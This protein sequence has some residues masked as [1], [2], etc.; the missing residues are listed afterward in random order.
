MKNWFPWILTGL[1]ALWLA[2][3][4][5]PP[6]DKPG[7]WAE[8]EFG[9]L[10]VV[11]NGRVQPLD[12]LARNSLLQLREKQRANT[13]PWK[14]WWEKPKILSATEWLLEVTLKPDVADTR[15]VFRVDNPDLKGL[16]AL[17]AE[18]AAARGLDG[19]HYSWQQIQPKFD[20][21]RREA[22]RAFGLEASRRRPYDQ[23]VMRLWTATSLYQR[24]KNTFS[25]VAS[26]DLEKAQAEFSAKMA[27]GRAAWQARTEGREFDERAMR[28]LSEQFDAPLI[29]PPPNPEKDRD[30]WM[31]MAEGLGQA[32]HGEPPPLGVAAYAKIASAYRQGNVE[33]F[34]QAVREYAGQ[35]SAKLAPELKKAQREQWFNHIEPFYKAMVLFVLAGLLAV[36]F[37][38]RPIAWEWLRRAALGVSVLALGI[39]TL[40][41][42]CRMLLEGRPPV[43]NLYSSAV[44]IGWASVG[45]GL[46]LERLWRNGVGVVVSAVV[47]FSTLLI[48]HHLSLSGDTMEMM[49]AVLDHN[50]WLAV[51]V[52]TITLGYA[53]TFVAGFLAIVYVVLGLATRMVTPEFGRSLDRMVYGI[54]CFATLF[55]FVGT[56]T[57]GIWADQSWGRFWGWDPKENG[58]LLIVLWTAI[59]L[60]ARWGN[61]VKTRGL[62]NLAIVGN[63]ITAWSWFGTNMLG[64]GLHSYG[65]MDKALV[66]LV[67]FVLSQVALVGLGLLPLR[68]WRSFKPI[69]APVMAPA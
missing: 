41:L 39:H 24:L 18:A 67:L 61:F 66:A 19:K 27:A 38:A 60:H 30:A 25:T 34:R 51:H 68:L 23:A 4:L 12:S 52:V 40:G 31:R 26:G 1:C 28:W 53:A 55:S 33:G 9:R 3:A 64:I 63:I 54:I 8:R 17:P 20:D 50:F 62:M 32:A 49:R 15:P 11:A 13:E 69:Q 5:R 65:F 58:A 46:L 21:L 2:A 59:I 22:H 35:L 10:P 37:W 14:S 43:T 44:F 42:V 6:T 29:L 48:A 36:G 47:G 57:G 16:L 56:V 7:A 45:L